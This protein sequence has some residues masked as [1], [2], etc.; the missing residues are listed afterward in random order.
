MKNIHSKLIAFI[1]GTVLLTFSSC[2]NDDG[3]SLGEMW[4]E[5]ATIEPLGDGAYYLRLDDGTKLW[6]AAS[7]V[8]FTPKFGR[9]QVNYTKL[10][11]KIGDY[12][13]YIK[14]NGL[15]Y[16]LTK[17]IVKLTA[18]NDETLGNDTIKVLEFWEGD[19]FLNIHFG[20]Q[21]ESNSIL[22]S[23]NMA[24][25]SIQPDGSVNLE[26]RHNAN[27]DNPRY[28][29]LGLVAFDLRPYKNEERDSVNFVIKVNSFGGIKEYKFTYKY[30]NTDAKNSKK[31]VFDGELTSAL[32]E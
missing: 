7:N 31:H 9:A 26:F 15:Q 13:H 29:V 1:L 14:V 16:I 2:T 5:I 3:Y 4:F 27:G 10:S 32:Y 23:I 22:H 21:A 8:I 6:P 24:E 12:D 20:Y 19:D 25:K 18:E 28:G 30:K 17:D 11:D